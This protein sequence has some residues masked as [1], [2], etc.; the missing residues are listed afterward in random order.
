LRC[1]AELFLRSIK[2]LVPRTTLQSGFTVFLIAGSRLDLTV[3]LLYTCIKL[4]QRVVVYKTFSGIHGQRV[5]L[6]PRVFFSSLSTDHRDSFLRRNDVTI[7]YDRATFRTRIIYL[8]IS[9]GRFSWPIPSAGKD[10]PEGPD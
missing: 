8:S 6:S 1:F 4:G 5:T 7:S 2:G 9:F 3:R 10:A